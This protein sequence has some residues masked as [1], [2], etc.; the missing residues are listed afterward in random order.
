[1]AEEPECPSCAMT[2]VYSW[3]IFMV[4]YL[5]GWD[6]AMTTAVNLLQQD[7]LS[8][9]VSGRTLRRPYLIVLSGYSIVV[10]WI[11][12]VFFALLVYLACAFACMTAPLAPK[13]WEKLMLMVARPI[14]V[15]HCVDLSHIMFH[16]LAMAAALVSMSVSIGFYITDEDLADSHAVYSKMLRVLFVCPAAMVAVYGLYIAFCVICTI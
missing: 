4:L 5:M 10:A 8:A 12:I 3:G 16:G 11:N 14:I 7:L 2:Q 15:L 13:W 9:Q 1:M 6:A